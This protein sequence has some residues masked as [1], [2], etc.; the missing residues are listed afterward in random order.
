LRRISIFLIHFHNSTVTFYYHHASKNEK[1]IVIIKAVAILLDMSINKI[2]QNVFTI[3]HSTGSTFLSTSKPGSLAANGCNPNEKYAFIFHGYT[4]SCQTQWVTDL[5]AN[6]AMYRGGC[7]IC[8]DYSEFAMGEYV[9]LVLGFWFIVK[10]VKTKIIQMRLE[11]FLPE[12]GYIF[13]FSFGAQIAMRAAIGGFGP[14][15]LAEL[16]A[17]DPAGPGFDDKIKNLGNYSKAAKNVQCIHTSLDKGTKTR[18]CDQNWNM[19]VCGWSQVGAMQPPMG[20]HGLCP[21]FYNSAFT[22]AFEAIP[23]PDFC[24]VLP[25]TAASWPAGFKMGYMETRKAQVKGNLYAAT[26]RNPPYNA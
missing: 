13:G 20:S 21:Y 9:D 18:T 14:R 16:D 3:L 5:K 7:I 2:S 25:N 24:P 17:C 19:G 22:N 6:L 12:N 11:R 8:V 15:S 26:F 10:V 1:N 23:R 4:Q